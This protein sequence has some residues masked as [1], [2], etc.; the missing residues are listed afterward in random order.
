MDISFAT[1]KLS[2][3][4]PQSTDESST[5]ISDDACDTVPINYGIQVSA[6]RNA[7]SSMESEGETL[8][9]D[10]KQDSKPNISKKQLKRL[11]KKAKWEE[12]KSE[13]R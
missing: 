3:G 4:Q 1:E 10:K 9:A 13:R 11:A 7:P 12:T 6:I 2:G 5:V 8:A